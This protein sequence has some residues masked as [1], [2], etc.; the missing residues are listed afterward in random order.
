MQREA[1]IQ[2]CIVQMRERRRAYNSSPGAMGQIDQDTMQSF[3]DSVEK[4]CCQNPMVFTA[5]PEA[6]RKTQLSCDGN[7]YSGG[8]IDMDCR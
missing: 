5:I 6:A 7:V 4:A 1:A 3:G 8:Q 2:S